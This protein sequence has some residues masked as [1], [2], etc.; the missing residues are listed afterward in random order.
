MIECYVRLNSLNKHIKKFEKAGRT[1]EQFYLDFEDILNYL[2]CK[3][4]NNASV[5]DEIKEYY[6]KYC[7][8]SK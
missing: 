4:H 7:A 6:N 1:N 5:D 8:A 2:S 3:D